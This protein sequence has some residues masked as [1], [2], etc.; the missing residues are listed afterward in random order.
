MFTLKKLS[1]YLF[2]IIVIAFT[3]ENAEAQKKIDLKNM[4]LIPGGY[5]T[6]G[7]NHGLDDEIPV[8]KVWVDSFYIDKYEVTNKEYKVFCDSTKAAY[9]TNPPWDTAYFSKKPEYPV[10]YVSWEDAANYAKWCGKRLP[11]EA[12]WEKAA[13]AECDSNYFCGDSITGNYANYSGLNGNDKWKNTSPGG[14]FPPNKYG[15][16]DMVGNVWEWCNDFYQKEY[17]FSIAG[18]NPAGP[19]NGALKVIRGGSWDSSP[20]FL[21]SS[22]RGKNNFKSKNS[23]IGFRCVYPV[24]K[25]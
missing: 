2:L 4:A 23:N 25:K 5:F 17:Y 3:S 19:K 10:I 20:E 6:L 11:T 16:Y 24:K 1:K 7:S 15:V 13:K 9:P 12:E 18:P 14:S 8:V 21:R 22:Q